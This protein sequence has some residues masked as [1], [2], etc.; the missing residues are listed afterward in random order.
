MKIVDFTALAAYSILLSS[1]KGDSHGDLLANELQWEKS[2]G[3]TLV[4]G[5]GVEWI[6]G[7]ENI[8]VTGADCDIAILDK[9]GSVVVS[10]QGPNETHCNS[11][12]THMP[13]G[14]FLQAVN[15]MDSKE[16]E[17]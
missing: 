1:V 3:F 8:L 7:G 15:Y 13:D 4:K 17:R 11:G 16:T 12:L 5:N 9:F 10:R 14:T 2:V 6:N